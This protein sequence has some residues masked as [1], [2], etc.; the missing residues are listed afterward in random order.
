MEE[1]V[2]LQVGENG[3]Q[4]QPVSLRGQSALTLPLWWCHFRV[5]LVTWSDR[6]Q[7]AG[8]NRHSGEGGVAP[9]LVLSLL[10][11]LKHSTD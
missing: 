11:L 5:S 4:S 1:R 9:V 7:A 8:G 10:R 3:L 2:A 6:G